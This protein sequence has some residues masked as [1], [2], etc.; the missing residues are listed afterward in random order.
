MEQLEYL[1]LMPN[2]IIKTILFPKK[3]TIK[4]KPRGKLLRPLKNG[5]S[6]TPDVVNLKLVSSRIFSWQENFTD[7]QTLTNILV[8]ESWTLL[9]QYSSDPCFMGSL[10]V[11]LPLILLWLELLSCKGQKLSISFF[12]KRTDLKRSK[13]WSISLSNVSTL[14][15]FQ[16]ILIVNNCRFKIT[17][18]RSIY[19]WGG[20]R[21]NRRGTRQEEPCSLWTVLQR[22]FRGYWEHCSYSA[23]W[24]QW[25][26]AQS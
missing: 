12:P 17:L 25:W 24:K 4:L 5:P 23:D 11:V 19:F 16:N 13:I 6:F 1:I 21:I 18:K 10:W 14:K 20:S 9:E 22:P 8:G 3:K 7:S 26:S 15:T 2:V